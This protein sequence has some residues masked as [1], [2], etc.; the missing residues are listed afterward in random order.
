MQPT[1]ASVLVVADQELLGWGMRVVFLSQDWVGRCLYAR[2]KSRAV[3]V[4][5]GAQPDVAIIGQTVGSSGCAAIA[6]EIREV[7]PRARIVLLT[8]RAVM[9]QE[10][11][12]ASH[13]SAYVAT[14]WPA[15]E[16][17]ARVRDVVAAPVLVEPTLAGGPVVPVLSR[18]QHRV[19][20]L[21]ASGATNREIGIELNLSPYTVQDHAKAVFR[22]LDVRNR[23]HAVQR[24]QRLGFIA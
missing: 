10:M 7:A 24:A 15:K 6:L 17:V 2:R 11:L 18:Q 5:L 9:S 20:R 23:A 14:A 21:M 13:A 19:L 12:A 22:R 3:S 1:E 4:A 8:D 16:I